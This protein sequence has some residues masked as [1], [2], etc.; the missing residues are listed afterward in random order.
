ML[1]H[2]K[3]EYKI[4][5]YFIKDNSS[6][7]GEIKV[8]ADNKT[9]IVI[10]LFPNDQEERRI[11]SQYQIDIS[12]SFFEFLKSG[13]YNGIQFD[14]SWSQKNSQNKTEETFF[15]ELSQMQMPLTEAVEKIVRYFRFFLNE[16]GIKRVCSKSTFWSLDGITWNKTHNLE[17]M[18]FWKDDFAYCV[19]GHS[20]IGEIQDLQKCVNLDIEP[21]LAFDYIYQAENFEDNPRRQWILTTI[22]LEYAMKE[23]LLGRD[24]IFESFI[25]EGKERVSL[26]ELYIRIFRQLEKEGIHLS[27]GIDNLDIAVQI[28]NFLIHRPKNFD[29]ESDE[30][31]IYMH[32]GRLTICQLFASLNADL[33]YYAD[34]IISPKSIDDEFPRKSLQQKLERAKGKK[35]RHFQP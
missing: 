30:V 1:I 29:I 5:G 14:Q 21:F 27:L 6:K 12:D 17:S 13:F 8:P 32:L 26:P 33:P 19:S 35:L 4:F 16:D 34:M 23:F 31:K 15:K 22:A 25:I 10:R 20:A 28:R 18:H 2:V 11:E 3:K 9:E 7:S 24:A